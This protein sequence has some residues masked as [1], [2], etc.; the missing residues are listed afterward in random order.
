MDINE[1]RGLYL[2]IEGRLPSLN[3]II[4]VA[5]A[6]RYGSAKQKKDTQEALAWKIKSQAGGRHFSNHVTVDI[7]FFEHYGQNHKRDDDNV[8]AGGCKFILDT[9][10]ELDIIKNDNP[11]WCHVK[12]ERFTKFDG[13]GH[14]EIRIWEDEDD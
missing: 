1:K 8:I 11:K 12:P 10:Q 9:L 4:K 2:N 7:R 3:D 14:I 13:A 5:R 6:N